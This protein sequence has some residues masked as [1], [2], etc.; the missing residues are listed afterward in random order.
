MA[1]SFRKPYDLRVVVGLVA[2]AVVL[3]ILN[4]L[5]VYEEQRVEWFGGPAVGAEED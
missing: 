4:N 2:L 3:G 5:R 1:I